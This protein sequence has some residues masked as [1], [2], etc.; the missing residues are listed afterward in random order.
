M[1]LGRSD[2]TAILNKYYESGESSLIVL[3]GR[4]GIGKTSLI[5]NFAKDKPFFYYCSAQASDRHHSFLKSIS[6]TTN[7]TIL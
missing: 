2:E 5:K 1:F 3:Y 4:T 7:L 6:F